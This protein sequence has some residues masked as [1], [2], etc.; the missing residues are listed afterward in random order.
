MKPFT[1]SDADYGR[2]WSY[3]SV[4]DA[5]ACW[6]WTRSF[7][8]KGYGRFYLSGGRGVLAHRAAVAAT[9]GGASPVGVVMHACDN[10]PCCNPA[11]LSV[12]THACNSRDMIAKGRSLR[13]RV[14]PRGELGPNRKLT[15]AAA[16]EIRSLRDKGFTHYA[17]A[18]KFGVSRPRIAQILK[19]KAW[20]PMPPGARPF[21]P[22]VKELP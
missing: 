8:N 19:G 4:G 12:G 1:L 22:R 7:N 20:L 6:P 15:Q 17:L 16:D 11:R 13:G 2:F 21:G 3:V 18:E 10:P 14:G 5:A 9:S